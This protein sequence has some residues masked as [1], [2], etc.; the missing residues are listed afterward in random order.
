MRATL[1][2]AAILFGL[3]AANPLVKR[4]GIDV[5]AYEEAN[6]AVTTTI[7][8]PIGDA[9]PQETASYDPSKVLEAAIAQA[10]SAP[11][12]S[13]TSAAAVVIKERAAVVCTTRTFNGP[14][15][16]TPTDSPE[17]FLAYAPFAASATSA[18]AAAAVPTGYNI[19]SGFVNLAFTAQTK[20]YL[21]YTSS[22]LTA[23]D[24]KQCAA[25]C[26]QMAGCTSFVLYYERVPLV[27]N[28]ADQLPND[29]ACPGYAN[30]TS[31]TLI[32]C[33][34]YGQ[35]VKLEEAT[36]PYQFQGK[37]K[38]VWAGANAYL[39]DFPTVDG[40]KPPVPVNNASIAAG[41]NGAG[42]I[43]Q[44]VFSASTPYDPT[45][46]AAA[47]NAITQ[48]NAL[49]GNYS[50]A[51]C[52]MFDAFITYKNG[53]NGVFTC[54]YYSIEF[55]TSAA[56]Y[57]GTTVG[58]NKY[59]IGFSNVYY[60]DLDLGATCSSLFITTTTV[61]P[62]A[63][64]TADPVINFQK[65]TVQYNIAASASP[66]AFYSACSAIGILA[67]TTTSTAPTVTT[68]VVPSATCT[69]GVEY[70]IYDLSRDTS[71]FAWQHVR[72][73]M[74]LSHNPS[75]STF[76]PNSILAGSTKVYTGIRPAM[77]SAWIG[78]D[79]DSSDIAQPLNLYEYSAT[80]GDSSLF[81][82]QH[83]GYLHLTKIGTYTF[84][85]PKPVDD[86]FGI[87]LYDNAKNGWTYGNS[88]HFST[89]NNHG[90]TGK[91]GPVTITV[92]STNNGTYVPFRIVWMNSDGP[93]GLDF[94][95]TDPDGNDLLSKTSVKNHQII[96][97]CSGNGVTGAPAFSAWDMTNGALGG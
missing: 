6:A 77:G 97:S 42:F 25:V 57:F 91:M 73:N 58:T 54:N 47:C 31:A 32:K 43:K 26:D 72:T 7:A 34:F 64:V 36:N 38:V 2:T 85:A 14:Q 3:A 22:K 94:R 63:T 93:Y 74:E 69:Q 33:A 59:T 79:T 10:T 40:F 41:T 30:S 68:T 48:Y 76:V 27:V 4:Q 60:L 8:P 67:T 82:M 39:R 62:T 83:R 49:N 52:T 88:A 86:I 71:S 89:F 19:V 13:D 78:Q 65:R 84:S 50:G 21:G 44:Q 18:A 20:N 35:P 61:L 95:L 16:T 96:T 90:S 23:Y 92:T 1:A 28:P 29:P 56:T 24:P 87:W 81:M 11:P 5:D 17:A 53:L 70:A 80:T 55:P 75:D 51:A 15:V 37:F 46:C 9:A 45:Q 66:S 12:A